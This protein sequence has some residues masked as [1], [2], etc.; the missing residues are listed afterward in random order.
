MKKIKPS[1]GDEIIISRQNKLY[2][3]VLAL[4]NTNLKSET[5]ILDQQKCKTPIDNI[6]NQ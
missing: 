4:F 6:N 2:M 5:D 1:I 3:H